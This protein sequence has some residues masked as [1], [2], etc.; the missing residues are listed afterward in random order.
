MHKNM[1]TDMH[2]YKS[3]HIDIHVSSV[4]VSVILSIS[5]DHIQPVFVSIILSISKDHIATIFVR[6]FERFEVV[7]NY[8]LSSCL[9]Y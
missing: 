9:L 6:D 1:H 2:I 7:T 5:K 4:F 3:M 8:H